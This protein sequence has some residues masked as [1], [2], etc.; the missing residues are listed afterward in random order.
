MLVLLRFS[1]KTLHP[2]AFAFAF[3]PYPPVRDR[4]WAQIRIKDA[5]LGC[6]QDEDRTGPVPGASRMTPFF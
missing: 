4:T 2:F 1:G 3:A 5:L 6:L